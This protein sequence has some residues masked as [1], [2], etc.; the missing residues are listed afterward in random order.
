MGK[1]LLDLAGTVAA[2]DASTER[3]REARSRF[4][5]NALPSYRKLAAQ[6]AALTEKLSEVDDRSAEQ[7]LALSRVMRAANFEKTDAV[8][9]AL[10]QKAETDNERQELADALAEIEVDLRR[11]EY[12]GALA[13]QQYVR[14]HSNAV[15]DWC[16]LEAAKSIAEHMEPLARALGLLMLTDVEPEAVAMAGNRMEYFTN[17]LSSALKT[18]AK[19]LDHGA[20]MTQITQAVG[21]LALGELAHLKNI[22]P[23]KIKRMHERL[24]ADDALTSA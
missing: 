11:L 20:L 14:D 2:Y 13:V 18:H 9:A 16:R 23:T 5:A 12:Q 24:R 8:K 21:P 19:Q 22:T 4:E 3:L 17:W 1:E 15:D 10:H 7:K 6:R